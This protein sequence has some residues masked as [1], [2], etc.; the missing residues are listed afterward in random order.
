MR[1]IKTIVVFSALALAACE[2][3]SALPPVSAAV[4]PEGTPQ[5]WPLPL[6]PEATAAENTL[7]V[8]NL[9]LLDNSGSMRESECSADNKEKFEVAKDAIRRFAISVPLEENLA[10]AAFGDDG[11]KMFVPFG[12]GK[13]QREEFLAALERVEANQGTPLR[14][15]LASASRMVS[16][17]ASRQFGY[18]T[19][20][21]IILTDGQ[22][23]DG[24][25]TL[26][27]IGVVEF[28]PI[29]IHTVGF[30]L[31]ST[32]ER[33]SLD[34]AGY[35]RYTTASNPDELARALASV[36]AEAPVFDATAFVPE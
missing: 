7:A 36:R 11:A 22:S 30:C 3:T 14:H 6:S 4:S 23:T 12:S 9:V 17:Q 16:E 27:A 24:D 1:R 26:T 15:A 5:P 20:R 31:P 13:A 32:D 10:L 33:H 35:T 19:Y 2:D 8:N 28:T 21:I 18:G 25:P 34:V 29:E